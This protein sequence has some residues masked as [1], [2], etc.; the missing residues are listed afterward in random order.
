MSDANRVNIATK[1]WKDAD[2]DFGVVPS[3]PKLLDFLRVSDSFALNP[4]TRISTTIRS[5]A[6]VQDVIR[7]NVAPA[8]DMAFNFSAKSC[9]DLIAALLRSDWG[10]DINLSGS[11]AVVASGQ[12]FSAN[13]ADVAT[14]LEE[15]I[16]VAASGKTYTSAALVDFVAAGFTIGDTVII[17]GDTQT[18]SDVTVSASGKTYTSAATIDFAAM[19]LVAGAKVTISGFGNPL[20][21]G[22]KTV[23][24]AIGGVLTVSETCADVG[25]GDPA[26]FVG[27]GFVHPENNGPHVV[28]NV[29]THVLTVTETLVDESPGAGAIFATGTGPT[30]AAIKVGQ[31]VKVAGLVATNNNGFFKVIAKDT[32]TGTHTI[33]VAGTGLTDA[34]A[35]AGTIKGSFIQNGIEKWWGVVEKEFLDLTNIFDAFATRIGKMTLTVKTGA[36]ITGAFS[37]QGKGAVGDGTA[38]VGDGANTAAPITQEM[39]AN[40]HVLAVYSDN[41]VAEFAASEI[42]FDIEDALRQKGKIALFGP[43]DIGLGRFT[44]KGTLV[45]YFEDRILLDKARADTKVGFALR[46]QDEDGNC[47]IFDLPA[48]R[49]SGGDP[50]VTGIDTDVMGNYT[51]DAMIDTVSGKMIGVSRFI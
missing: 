15:D 38:T 40:D 16:T 34:G 32:S 46:L 45:T 22:I 41:V 19:G 6:Q 2:E 51:F 35:H 24:T 12:K 14:T 5:D 25:A 31:W 33:S 13:Q 36:E 44:I 47:Y 23:V 3:T 7:T 50:A 4:T 9:D 43:F 26:T 39:N 10:N 28:T 30:F 42:T 20:N 8:G 18:G 21:N 29:A 49:I 48:T 11:L 27:A 1:F 17:G 37:F